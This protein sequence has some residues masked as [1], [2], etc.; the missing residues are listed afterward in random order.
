MTA[1]S[2]N[3]KMWT[4]NTQSIINGETR[5]FIN[6]VSNS[7]VLIGKPVDLTGNAYLP[8]DPTTVDLPC[9]WLNIVGQASVII[10]VVELTRILSTYIGADTDETE[11]I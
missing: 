9:F 4:V 3:V 11:T 5:P 10:P 6:L 7:L 8:G 2:D 1:L